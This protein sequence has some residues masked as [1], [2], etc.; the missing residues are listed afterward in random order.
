MVLAACASYGKSQPQ[1]K[2]T[3]NGVTATEQKISG[4]VPKKVNVNDWSKPLYTLD[5]DKDT[6]TKWIYDAKGLL[7]KKIIVD[8]KYGLKNEIEY[9]YEGNKRIYKKKVNEVFDDWD[10]RH[11]FWGDYADEIV[12]EYADAT[13][14]KLVAINGAEVKYDGQGRITNIGNGYT[15][16]YSE[17]EKGKF[18]IEYTFRDDIQLDEQNRVIYRSNT[19]NYPSEDYTKYSYEGNVM[20]ITHYEKAI[21]R[22]EEEVSGNDEEPEKHTYYVYF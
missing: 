15:Y 20:T 6:I 8:K 12:D 22:D 21:Y 17:G 16:R 18:S 3:P 19:A 14:T 1:Q 10:I 7:T 11:C 2:T 5:T 13:F 4:L 9:R